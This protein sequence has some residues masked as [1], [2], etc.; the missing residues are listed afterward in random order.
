MGRLLPCLVRGSRCFCTFFTGFAILFFLVLC[1]F[2]GWILLVCY[3]L[4]LVGTSGVDLFDPRFEICS[5]AFVVFLG[6]VKCLCLCDFEDRFFMGW[7]A[8]L[9]HLLVSSF[10]KHFLLVGKILLKLILRGI[11]DDLNF[12]QMLNCFL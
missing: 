3:L 11:E 9:F 6:T 1:S 8:S 4:D 10:F 2:V 5:F 12:Q 7:T